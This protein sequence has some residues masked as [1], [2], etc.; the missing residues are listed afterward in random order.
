MFHE[1][2]RIYHLFLVM[3]VLEEACG[4]PRPGRKSFIWKWE[5][6]FDTPSNIVEAGIK[7]LKQGRNPLYFKSQE[8]LSYVTRYHLTTNALRC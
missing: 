7:A 4:C 1:S 6:D 8:F 5:T 3:D 2:L